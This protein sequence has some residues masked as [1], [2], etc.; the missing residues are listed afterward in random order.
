MKRNPKL[1]GTCLVDCRPQTGKCPMNC[2]QCFYNREGAFYE[3]IYEPSIPSPLLDEEAGGKIVRMNAGHD[4]NLNRERVLETAKQYEDVFFNTS[5]PNFNFPGPVVYTA[6]REEEVMR[7]YNY[8]V[9]GDESKE[10]IMFVRLRVSATNLQLVKTIACSWVMEDVPVVLTFMRYYTEPPDLSFPRASWAL[11]K[12]LLDEGCYEQRKH[13]LNTYW[14][15]TRSF[16]IHAYHAIKNYCG[17]R[18]VTM[19]GT[20]DSDLCRHCRNCE[21]YYWITKKRLAIDCAEKS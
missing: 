18:L 9:N 13:V 6:N 11:P 1:V 12:S 16:K 14:C 7:G 19:C 8:P 17:S 21:Y 2:N 4:S 10:N 5:I 20:L 3:D 15:P